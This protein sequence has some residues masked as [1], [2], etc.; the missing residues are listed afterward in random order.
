MMRW[1]RRLAGSAI[2]LPLAGC[3]VGPDYKQPSTPMT[4][5]YKEISPAVYRGAGTW[6]TAQPRDDALRGAWWKIFGDGELDALEDELTGANQQLRIAE[7]NFRQARAAIGVARSQ[8]FPT[9]SLGST[10]A[11]IQNSSHQPYS[12]APN[13]QPQGLFQLPI[14]LT[15]EIDVWGSIRRNVAAAREEAQASAADLATAALSLHAELALDYI[16][17]R[18]ADAQAQLLNDTVK[19]YTQALSLTQS[20]L[21]G[22][23][24]PA[25][26]VAQAQT[27]LDTVQ[28]QATDIGVARAQYEH[29]IAILIGRPPAAF[30]LPPRPLTLRPPAIPVG[31]PS[32]LLQRRPDIA[33]AER[34]MA[35]ANERIGI[36]Q[37]AY[38]PAVNLS[39]LTGFEGN[40]LATWFGWPSLFWAVGLSVTQTVFEGGL[41]RAQSAQALAVYDGAVANYRQ[42]T[43]G[44]FQQVEDNLS[45]LR[46]LADEARQQEEAV[47]SA[48]NSV[49]IFTNRYVGGEDA[50]LQVINAQTF[51]LA[52][53]RNDVD[54]RRR[55]MEASVLLVKALGGGWNLM[56]LP[57]LR[58]SGL[59]AAKDAG[60]N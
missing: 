28:V 13:P 38:Y 26:D 41:R 49:R 5:T 4:E 12:L 7:A 33:A 39:A 40:S 45:A 9:L 15:Y 60:A 10:T 37:A 53:E 18:A 22:G 35:E 36:A 2:A 47:R 25:S 21:A 23:E 6:V 54:I 8:E 27:Q 29:A 31:L 3:M 30:S 43:L 16:E 17:L 1:R 57:A 14:D 58:G 32:E 34:R 20:R 42:T 55:R 50:Y 44:A 19:A 46:I 59:H 56:D 51:E 48:Q 11:S 24:A 52:N